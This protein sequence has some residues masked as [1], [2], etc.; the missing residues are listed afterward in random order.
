[1]KIISFSNRA[2]PPKEAIEAATAALDQPWSSSY[3]DPA[4][5]PTLRYEIAKKSSRV[6]G[7]VADPDSEIL[8][9]VGAKQAMFLA[10]MAVV[11]PN[12]EVLLPDPAWVSYE[13]CVR[14]AGGRV[15]RFPLLEED[16]FQPD[17]DAIR[18]LITPR[19]RLI[20][21][22]TPHNP[23]GSVLGLPAL[24]AI[25]I[26]AQEHNLTVLSDE[27]Y[28]A[29]VYGENIHVSIASL[30]GMARRTVTISSTSKLFNMFGWRIGWAISSSRL[31]ERMGNIQQHIAGCATSFAQA[32]V[33]AVLRLVE[34][35]VVKTH[36][37]EC[38]H[39]RDA[40]VEG[41]N[42]LPGITCWKPSGSY[43]AFPNVQ[44]LTKRSGEIAT[45]LLEHGG[46]QVIPGSAFGVRGEGYLRFTFAC[47]PSDV[48]AG[49]A[50]LRTTLKNFCGTA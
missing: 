30:P 25:A 21:L 8:V 45:F 18:E 16:N 39:A 41:L 36:V 33:E 20:I 37:E 11:N 5:T 6:N 49:I 2:S 46:I 22:N 32:G 44:K 14:L 50:R 13:P 15:I 35:E 29:Y 12:D 27:V 31:I 23:T 34:S 47:T 42:S 38:A 3:T 7:I 1:V 24:Q 28:E 26:F 19:T 40:L 17:V 9:T 43:F 48:V 10:I 4:G